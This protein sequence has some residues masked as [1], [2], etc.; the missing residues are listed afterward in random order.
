MLASSKAKTA[1]TEIVCCVDFSPPSPRTFPA[2]SPL[3]TLLFPIIIS[4]FLQAIASSA[5]QARPSNKKMQVE[6]N[7]KIQCYSSLTNHPLKESVHLAGSRRYEAKI[8]IKS[9]FHIGTLY[10][11]K[12]RFASLD[13][14][15]PYA[16]KKHLKESFC[17]S[18]E[19]KF[20][21]ALDVSIT[22]LI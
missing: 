5:S 6:P 21:R 16:R 7:E 8:P 18:R 2:T 12:K 10:A 22:A 15:F 20:P 17:L 11:T 19:C 13:R 9:M 4:C 14:N 3:N 1:L